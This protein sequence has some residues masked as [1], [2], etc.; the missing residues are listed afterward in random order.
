MIADASR[1][2]PR[3]KSRRADFAKPPPGSTCPPIKGRHPLWLWWVKL[4]RP[5]FARSLEAP[6]SKFPRPSRSLSGDAACP[7]RR[8]QLHGGDG[9]ARTHQRFAVLCRS[10]HCRTRG[11]IWPRYHDSS[12]RVGAGKTL[13]KSHMRTKADAPVVRRCRRLRAVNACR[14]V[15][16][17]PMRCPALSENPFCSP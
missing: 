5:C 8:P 14:A 12:A 6:C 1:A 4:L 16:C 10:R 3:R 13:A 9:A 17:C 7:S 15:L 2:C 11:Q